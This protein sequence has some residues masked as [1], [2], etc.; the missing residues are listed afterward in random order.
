[1]EEKRTGTGR[2]A[3]SRKS[4]AHEQG[5]IV[6]TSDFNPGARKEA[7]RPDA[8]PVALMNG[9]QLVLLLVEAGIGVSRPSHDLIEL[10]E[11]TDEVE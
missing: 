9:K 1:M 3:S 8:V 6:T 5:L 11:T 7:A 4:W 10:L 2:S